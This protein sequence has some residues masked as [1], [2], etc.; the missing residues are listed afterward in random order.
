LTPFV[1][2]VYADFSA[3]EVWAKAEAALKL[4]RSQLGRDYDLWVAG[5]AHRTGDLLISVNPSRPSEVVGRHHKAT[6]ELANRAIEDAHAY[7]AVWSRTSP[8]DRARLLT[9]AAA[10]LRERKFEFDA[11]LVLEAGKTW[12]EAEAEVAEAI[13]FCEYYARQMVR[14]AAPE[15]VVQMPGE[16]DDLVYLPLGAGVIIPPWNFPL[17]ILA[18]MAVAA[19]VTGNTVVIKPS[20]ETPTVAAKFV[21]I[22]HEAGF[23][24]RSLALC[25]GSGAVIGDLLVE[26]PKTR[27]VSFTGSREVGLRINELAAKPRKGQIWIKRV[28]AEMGGKDAIIVDREADLDSAVAGVVQSAFGYQGQKCSA[29]SRA[30]VDDPV[31]DEFVEKLE[32]KVAA[33]KVGAP[34]D[35]STFMGPVI[36]AGARET[37]LDYIEVGRG[38]GRLIAGGGV[39]PGDG[40]FVQPTVFAG[41]ESKA[42]VFQ[43][44]IFGPVLTVSRAR[45]F[46]HAL[47]LANDTEYG[48][49]GAVYSRNPETIHRAR[50]EFFVGNLYI[51]RKCTGAMVG[52]HPFGGFNMSGTD[53]KAGGPD[54][55]LQFLQAK[56]IAEKL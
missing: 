22:L 3:P 40:Y 17:A 29:C 53:S 47:E 52:S 9:G 42:R 37:I 16:R 20:S 44:E 35:R 5:A 15:A 19:L 25:T 41:V 24:P 21:E 55:L 36:S 38:E 43:E 23:P 11:W 30:I 4:V 1:N 6:A 14:F 13:D 8:V 18:G 33:L 27:F 26:H 50:Q 49:T 10:L 32:A 48:L 12:P 51:N 31:Y 46:S 54:Y 7:A 28:V 56:S 45:D 39:L 34:E 2:E